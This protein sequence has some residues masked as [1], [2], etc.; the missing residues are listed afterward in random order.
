MKTCRRHSSKSK[1]Q[2]RIN[3]AIS[4]VLAHMHK[5]M[6]VEEIIR[7]Q[8]TERTNRSPKTETVKNLR[9]NTLLRKLHQLLLRKLGSN[10][11]SFKLYI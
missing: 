5:L 7:D 8:L 6:R 3:Q 1:H 9:I 2:G 11:K 4:L 10:K